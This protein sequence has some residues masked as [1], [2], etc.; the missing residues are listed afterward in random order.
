MSII[1]LEKLWS[2]LNDF[3]NFEGWSE[4]NKFRFLI[5]GGNDCEIL[6]HILS[7]IEVV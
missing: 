7:F 5:M 1:F 4:G 3:C 6:S 2:E